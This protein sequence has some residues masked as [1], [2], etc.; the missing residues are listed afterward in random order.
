MRIELP[1]WGRLAAG[2]EA[3]MLGAPGTGD[4]S[5][6]TAQGWRGPD[7]NKWTW[8]TTGVVLAGWAALYADGNEKTIESAGDV[9]QFLPIAAGIGMTLR[10]PRSMPRAPA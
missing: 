6:Y 2:E 8:I 5:G 1:D 4:R 10:P 7:T 9:T 3:G